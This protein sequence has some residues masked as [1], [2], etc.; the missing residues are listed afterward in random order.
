MRI[1]E[2]FVSALRSLWSNKRRSILTMLGIVIGIAAVITILSLGDGVRVETL[3][4]LQADS[5]GQQSSEIRFMS[6]EDGGGGGVTSDG[7][8]LPAPSSNSKVSGFNDNDVSK[9]E[10]NP[11]VAKVKLQSDDDGFI[12]SQGNINSKSESF[13]VYLTKK[14]NHD[15]LVAGRG[16][17]KSDILANNPV[18][19]VDQYTAKKAYRTINNALNAGIELNGINYT[20]VGIIR[21]DATHGEY[22]QYQIAVPRQVYMNNSGI[23]PKNTMKITFVKGADVSKETKK[24]AEHLNSKGSQHNSGSYEYMD[25]SEML[26]GISDTIQ[27]ITLFVVAIAGIS[28]F[29]AG[30]G[31]MNMMYISV[32]ERTQEIGIRMAVG[33]NQR[34]ILWQF[35]IEAIA[36]TL[37]GGVIGYLAGIGLA[38]AISSFLPFKA[39]VTLSTFL[40]AFGTST[41]IGLIFGILPAKTASRKNLIEILR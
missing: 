31:V 41:I 22:Q 35:L 26:K 24:I 8:M 40:L 23:V 7:M 27:M 30:I 11:K 3:K 34:Q 4:S 14:A 38:Q 6:N 33:A 13:H 19:L 1:R 5:S 15:H 17:S 29:I 16:I 36:L 25:M 12:N 18:A 21:D 32:S 9:A 39:T 20:I 28:L 37:T 10:E 2:L